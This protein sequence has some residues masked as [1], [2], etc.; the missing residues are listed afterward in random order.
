VSFDS[1]SNSIFTLSFFLKVE[2]D[3]V[4]PHSIIF[5]KLFYQTLYESRGSI[6]TDEHLK[7]FFDDNNPYISKLG[8]DQKLD[9]EGEL[10]PQETLSALKLMKKGKSP[11]IKVTSSSFTFYVP[12][13]FSSCNYTVDFFFP[14]NF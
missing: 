9:L 14:Y 2:Y 12:F 11:G 8:Q 10:T 7:S 4:L 5:Q 3:M 6:F 1:S 13:S